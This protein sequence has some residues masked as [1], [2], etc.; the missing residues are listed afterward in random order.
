[1]QINGQGS[2]SVTVADANQESDARPATACLGF[3]IPG[4]ADSQHKEFNLNPVGVTGWDVLGSANN[5]NLPFH[6]LS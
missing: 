4:L 5:F 3:M 6:F 2:L 1:M